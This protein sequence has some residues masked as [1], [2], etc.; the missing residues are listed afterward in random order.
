M[1]IND[2][3]QAFPTG[4]V[5]FPNGEIIYGS[6][7]MTL[8]D[9]FAGLIAAAL[10]GKQGSNYDHAGLATESYAAADAMISERD[11]IHAEFEVKP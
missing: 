10:A 5:R 1:K 8:R 11:V 4:E 6:P 3:G 2:G 9:W 7:G